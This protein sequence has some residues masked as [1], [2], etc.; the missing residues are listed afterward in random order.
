MDNLLQANQ[1]L[2]HLIGQD[3]PLHQTSTKPERM[4]EGHMKQEKNQVITYSRLW[5]RVD[6]VAME[7]LSID[8]NFYLDYRNPQSIKFFNKGREKLLGEPFSRKNI[9]SWLKR[10]EIKTNEFDWI[11]TLTIDG[12]LFTTHIVELSMETVKKAAQES[13]NEVQRKA[14][15]RRMLFNCIT[16]SISPSVMDKLQLYITPSTDH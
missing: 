15:N 7:P 4:T 10:H 14:Q 8:H 1:D 16:S 9:F 12:K 6:V 11:P 3:L 13:Q 5:N 2:Q